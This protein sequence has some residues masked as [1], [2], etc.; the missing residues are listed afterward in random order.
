MLNK[1][2]ILEV[3]KTSNILGGLSDEILSKIATFSHE[4]TYLPGETIFV[5]GDVAEKLHIVEEGE[6]ALD[7]NLSTRPGSI[8]RGTID[9]V[10]PREAFG[11]SAI[12][13]SRFA[14]SAR[15]VS[16][17]KTIAVDGEGLRSLLAQEPQICAVV[18]RQVLDI[19]S[20][21]LSHTRTTLAHILSV[22][23]HDLKAP[24]AAVQSYLQVILGG[25]VG[26][27]NEKQKEMLSRSCVRIAEFIEMIDNILDVSRFEVGAVEMKELSLP[28]V[29][30]DSVEILRPLAEEKKLN[31]ALDLPQEM[32]KIKGSATRLKQVIT[33][34]VG[35]AVKFTP[36]PGEISVKLEEDDGYLRVEVTD[37]GVGISNEELPRIFDE[38]YRGVAGDTEAKGTGLGL[39]IS[40][41]IIEAHGG[42]IWAES[43]CPET[44]SGSKFIFTLPKKK[45]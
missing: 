19:A 30:R 44:G 37:T 18:V 36:S 31:L 10:F 32:P 38:F 23:S 25:F 6:V 42:R 33:N 17:T 4:E 29:V 28:E 12:L 15:A 2:A 3:L 45:T 20:L 1:E 21:R 26:E 24:L 8:R 27:L 41:K 39:S 34:L 9:T 5:E 16:T 11:W 22:A 43:P 7:I 13:E 14:M 35:N 40:K